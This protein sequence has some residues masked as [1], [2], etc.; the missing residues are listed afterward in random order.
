LCAPTPAASVL[1]LCRA[2]VLLHE[3]LVPYV[4][5]AAR[6][7]AR[8]GLPIVCPLCLVDPPDPRGR[9]IGDAYGYGP[10]L[11]VAPVLVERSEQR[12]QRR[13]QQRAND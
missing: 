6:T 5:G 12:H 3:Q 8:A 1:E 11:W 9:A 13:D 4:R 10:A 2:Y 7:A